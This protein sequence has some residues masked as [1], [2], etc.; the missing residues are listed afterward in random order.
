MP[1][2][3]QSRRATLGGAPAFDRGTLSAVRRPDR[4]TTAAAEPTRAATTPTSRSRRGAR[5]RAADARRVLADRAQA[6]RSR[7]RGRR[8]AR[9]TGGTALLADAVPDSVRPPRPRPAR[10]SVSPP[11]PPPAARRPGRRPAPRWPPWPGPRSG[12]R[13]VGRRCVPAE[14]GAFARVLA[15]MAAA[16]AQQAVLLAARA[17]RTAD[18]P[19]R[20]AAADP[21]RG[22]R[23]RLGV[24]RARR[25]G[26]LLGAAALRHARSR[27]RHPP[28]PPRPAHRDVRA[29]GG[30]PVAAA[31]GYDLPGPSGPPASSTPRGCC[32]SGAAR[33]STRPGTA[34]PRAPTGSG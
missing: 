29:S 16:A 26:L 14:S 31:V 5:R 3:A 22:A 7:R 30:A 28:G 2:L 23:G 17:L 6:A 34:A 24:R 13:L 4:P 8:R 33:R 25:P 9:C 10:P 18:D 1:P 27:L 32:W 15:S 21:R 19:A 11:V 12:C 20:G